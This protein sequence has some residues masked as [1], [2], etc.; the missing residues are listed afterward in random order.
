MTDVRASAISLPGVSAV[1]RRSR[2]VRTLRQSQAAYMLLAPFLVLFILVLAYPL[3]YFLYLSVFDATLNK[4]PAFVGG[5][6]FTHLAVDGEFLTALRNTA[7]FTVFVVIGETV[8]P[9]FMAIATAVRPP[10]WKAPASGARPGTSP[11]RRC[12]RSST[13]C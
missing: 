5:G 4:A 2:I 7:F 1:Q 9:L 11:S 12:G 6:N 3:L 13:S 10:R 8:L